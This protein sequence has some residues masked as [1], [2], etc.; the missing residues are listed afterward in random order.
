MELESLTDLELE[1]ADQ[2]ISTFMDK[3]IK[4]VESYIN[5]CLIE[6][7]ISEKPFRFLKKLLPKL[8]ERLYIFFNAV[9]TRTSFHN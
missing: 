6:R 5:A 9:F 8:E 1:K 7:L 2:Q 3:Q 4:V